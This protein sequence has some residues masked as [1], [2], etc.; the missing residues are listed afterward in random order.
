MFTVFLIPFPSTKFKLGSLVHNDCQI[1]RKPTP[2]RVKYT[3]QKLNTID[4]GT[5]SS[6]RVD[7][8]LEVAE[9]CRHH[10]RPLAPLHYANASSLPGKGGVW[11]DR[12]LRRQ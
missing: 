12:F 8:A 10:R 9:V 1:K 7:I 2:R 4:M 5:K 6:R 11:Q 3:D